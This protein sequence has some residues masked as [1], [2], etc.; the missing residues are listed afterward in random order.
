[1]IIFRC[2]MNSKLLGKKLRII[3]Q[4]KGISQDAIAVKLNISQVAY[5]KMEN[6]III[7]TDERLTVILRELNISI[8]TLRS[9]DL[10]EI[11]KERS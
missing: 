1:M 3:R 4:M 5:S 7:I 8:D 10:E 9:F 6:G 11:F 2:Y